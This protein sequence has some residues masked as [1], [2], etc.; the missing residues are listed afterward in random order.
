MNIAI[1]NT[2]LTMTSRE[3]AELTVKRHPDVKRDIERMLTDLKEDARKFA[4]IYLDSM[5][6]EQT[7]YHLDRELTDTLLTGYNA[8]LRRKVIARWRELE[9]SIAKGPDLSSA[10]VLRNMLLEYSEKVIKL[11]SKVAAD[12][13]KVEFAETI[14]AMEGVCHVEKVA[15]TLGFGRN[16]FFRQ[17]RE[18]GI[19]MGSNLPYQKYINKQYFTVIEQEPY[20]DSKG[21]ERP[22]FTAMVTGAG[23]VF[24][25]RKYAPV[26]SIAMQ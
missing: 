13:P 12:A 1:S 6:R 23:Q 9:S 17:L 24:L 18:D 10:I 16:K 4:H 19:L 7:E 26:L 11:E 5:K 25:Q 3:I 22:R 8:L 2:P 20:T 21:V 15:K 14:R